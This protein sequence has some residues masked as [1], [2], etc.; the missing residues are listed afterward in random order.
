MLELSW[1]HSVCIMHQDFPY[2][3][4]ANIEKNNK[5]IQ[6][7]IV[8]LDDAITLIS[9]TTSLHSKIA[10]YKGVPVDT[11]A[12]DLFTIKDGWNWKNTSTIVLLIKEE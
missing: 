11:L 6:T 8:K 5:V 2:L 10:N 12:Q 4:M 3:N 1:S 7:D 9:P